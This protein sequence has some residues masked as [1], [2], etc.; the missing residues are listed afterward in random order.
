[1]IH[2]YKSGQVQGPSTVYLDSDHVQDSVPTGFDEIKIVNVG[3]FLTATGNVSGS[4]ELTS[5]N[6]RNV[7]FTK[8]IDLANITTQ[9]NALFA[10]GTQNILTQ[11]VSDH[12]IE[13]VVL[14]VDT[15]SDEVFGEE[16]KALC[17]LIKVFYAFKIF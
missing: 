6:K 3:E 12:D 13:K 9:V 2:Y 8:P 7:V 17:K 5:N 10:S 1:M 16:K 11:N 15:L 4:I 14:K